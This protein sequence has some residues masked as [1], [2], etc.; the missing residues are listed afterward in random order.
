MRG[1]PPRDGEGDHGAKRHG[2]G[3]PA[4]LQAPIKTVKLAR[5]LRREMSPAEAV[6]WQQLRQRP[7]GFRF[8][9]QLPLHPYSLDF[10]CVATRLA[11][12]VDGEAHDRG[13]RP[14]RDEARDRYVA[15]AGF[16]TM[17]IPAV[18]VFRNLEG[19]LM[20]IVEECRSRGP[21]HPRAARGCPPPRSGEEH[22]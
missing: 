18:E 2:G 12:E 8:R 4:V 20:G 3:G 7:G 1:S 22:R 19:V 6:L 21:L 15:A 11:V 9:R 5:R 16:V 13:D 17:R 10:A 14:Q